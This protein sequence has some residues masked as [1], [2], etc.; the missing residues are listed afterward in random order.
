MGILGESHVDS[1]MSSFG[2]VVT[3]IKALFKSDGLY[4]HSGQEE[5]HL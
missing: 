1:N 4:H 3:V 2:E 5:G